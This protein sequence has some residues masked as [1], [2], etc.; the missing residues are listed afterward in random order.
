MKAEKTKYMPM[1]RHQNVGPNHN[2]MIANVAMFKYLGRTNYVRGM[3]ATIHFRIFFLPVSYLKTYRL[4]YIKY[5]F[6]CYFVWVWNVVS[7]TKGRTYLTVF[8]NSV[9]KRI[10]G[11]KREVVTGGWRRLHNEELRKLYDSPNIIM[12]IK[13][14]TM[15]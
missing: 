9:L 4:K 15:G 3:A 1:S 7:H 6:I 8:E 10:F 12:V 2:L 14:R 13:S 11:A 5:H